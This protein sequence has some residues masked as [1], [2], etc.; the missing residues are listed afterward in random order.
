MAVKIGTNID[1]LRAQRR[2]SDA[3]ESLGTTYERLSSGQ[4][5]NRASDDAAGLAVASLLN[6]HARIFTQGVRNL[7]DATSF[8]NIA[9]GA[10]QEL[11]SILIRI[12]ELAEQGANGS[13]SN[14]QRASLDKEGQALRDEFNRI[15]SST[16]FNG[17]SLLDGSSANVQIQAGLNDTNAPKLVVG[18]DGFANRAVGDG[19]FKA[20]VATPSGDASE[21]TS[22][23]LNGDGKIDL[24]TAEYGAARVGVLLGNGDGTFQAEVGYSETAAV[25]TVLTNDFNGDGKLDVVALTLDGFVKVRLGNGNGTLGAS[26]AYA[27]G[28]GAGSHLSMGDVDG[29][30]VKDIIASN[31]SNNTINV[32]IGNANG[33]FK[34]RVSYATATEPVADA[35]ADFDG[36]GDLDLITGSRTAQ[37]LVVRLNAGNGTFG[38]AMTYNTPGYYSGRLAVGD[39]NGDGRA[40][41]GIGLANVNKYQILLANSDGSFSVGLS[42]AA[43]DD[44]NDATAGDINGDGVLDLIITSVGGGN[45]FT[46]LGNGNGTFKAPTSYANGGDQLALFADVTGDG[47]KDIISPAGFGTSQKIF[48][49]NGSISA[50]LGDFSLLTRTSALATLGIADTALATVSATL[51]KIGSQ[52]SRVAVEA[53][54][55]QTARENYLAA[56]E[57]ITGADIASESAKLIATGIV[58]KAG[59]AVLAQANQAPSLALTLLAARD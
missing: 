4:R 51:G 17:V 48:V 24:I 14:T 32:L 31:Q 20:G 7:N 11:S 54:T 18:V 39:F 46:Y 58:Q 55:L 16:K 9:E 22:G 33:T 10:G 21:V 50:T 56:S 5:I 15:V 38:G 6:A 53:R 45:L 49:G 19:T 52:Q 27:V 37:Q 25:N 28:G 2:L 42:I 43:P 8:L 35:L 13:Y 44:L 34:A 12:K 57:R 26:T 1:S 41:V 23:D 3:T 59:A 40:D 29:D 36:D 47:I 30:G